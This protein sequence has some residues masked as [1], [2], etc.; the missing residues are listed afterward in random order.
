MFLKLSKRIILV[1]LVL[2]LGFSSTIVNSAFNPE[3]NYQGKLTDAGGDPVD[4]GNY[5]MQFKLYTVATG[6]TAIWTETLTLGNRTALTSGLF[7]VLLGNITSISGIDF[8]QDLY[9]GV[10]VG[11]TADTPDWDGE[12]SPRKQI[13]SVPS[14]FEAG[15]LD[16]LDSTQFV[17]S[18]Q[19]GSVGGTLT[20]GNFVATSTSSHSTFVNASST[21][22]TI[23]NAFVRSNTISATNDSGINIYDNASNGISIEDGGNIG[24]GSAAPGKKLDVTGDVG[25]SGT[26]TTA[27]ASTTLLTSTT[28]WLGT[29]LSGVWNGTAI[30]ISDYTNLVG[31][32]NITLSGDT[33]N[34]DD[35]F[36]VND[37]D[38]TTTGILTTAGLVVSDGDTVGA[39]TNKWLFDDSGGDITATGGNVGVGITAPGAKLNASSTTEQLRLSYDATNYASFTVDSAS[40][41]TMAPSIST[42]TTTIGSGDEALRISSAGNVGV[43]I[44]VPVYQLQLST[45]SAAKP[46]TSSWAVDS[47]ERLKD[48]NGDFTRGLDALFSLYPSYF[49]YKRENAR[50]IPSNREY[51]GLIAQDVQKVIPEAVREGSD[52]YL[53]IESDPIFWTMLNAIKEL[54]V[55]IGS[56]TI[57]YTRDNLTVENDDGEPQ[58]KIGYDEENYVEMQVNATGN[59]GIN[60]T[61]TEISL[62][63]DNLS[64]CSDGV[65]PSSADVMEGTGNLVVENTAYINEA[66]GVGTAEPNRTL[67]VFN[68]QTDPQMRISYDADQYSELGVSATGDLT[69]STQGGDVLALDEN[70]KVCSGDG[71]PSSVD[72]I[73]GTGNLIVENNILALGNVGINTATPSYTLDVNGTLRAHGITDASDRRLKTNIQILENSTLERINNL[74]GVTFEWIDENLGTGTQIGMIAQELEEEYPT[75]VNT[76]E[77][78][79]KSIQYGKFTAVLLES[80]KELFSWSS[81]IEYRSARLEERTTKLEEENEALKQRVGELE[82]RM[83]VLE[84][85]LPN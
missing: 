47:D 18:D 38:D 51:V 35:S 63:D 28:S 44:T 13:A 20:A 81:T 11:G 1:S 75:L 49:N 24:I 45:D 42:A 40:S 15:K 33:L 27:N 41:L 46:G 61:G 16:G 6:G 55:E 8:N 29:I 50:N 26:L 25:V 52:G 62:P 31:G 68:T 57:S 17:R 14:A 83:G 43:G 73:E 48:I 64:V 70:L 66:L 77:K 54:A 59:L 58:V 78:G 56:E 60:T 69:I 79:F 82:G 85:V 53:S 34:V 10:N 23:G 22:Q 80:I 36:L 9:L 5:N 39:A 32:T 7:S 67:D 3:I 84:Q 30:D 76:D 72:D 37:A 21:Q 74:R 19:S 65:C 2:T 4:N 12:M 71:C